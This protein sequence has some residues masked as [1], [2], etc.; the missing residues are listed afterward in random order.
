MGTLLNSKTI[1]RTS[2][3]SADSCR[4]QIRKKKRLASS[5]IQKTR[6]SRRTQ[7]LLCCL[8]F[9]TASHLRLRSTCWIRTKT[10]GRKNLMLTF[11]RIKR[12]TTTQKT[13][14][15]TARISQCWKESSARSL[16]DTRSGRRW[17]RDPSCN[18]STYRNWMLAR[19]HRQAVKIKHDSAAKFCIANLSFNYQSRYL[20]VPNPNW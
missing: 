2:F 6:P 19:C 12:A 17:G 20:T 4:T 18:R 14:Q 9:P 10:R 13:I 7:V 11:R 15:A 8:V 3:N 16:Q 5:W 1:T